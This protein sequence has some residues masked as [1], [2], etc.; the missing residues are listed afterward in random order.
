MSEIT[1]V[2]EHDTKEGYSMYIKGLPE[3]F[4]AQGEPGRVHVV[5]CL[6][7][8]TEHI[9]HGPNLLPNPGVMQ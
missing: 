7:A 4:V 5:G 2:F 3:F 6:E 8:L 9:K 1:I